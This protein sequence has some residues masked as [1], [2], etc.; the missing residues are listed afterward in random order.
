MRTTSESRLQA[1]L[2]YIRDYHKKNSATPGYRAIQKALGYSSLSIVAADVKKLKER[3]WIDSEDEYGKARIAVPSSLKMEGVRP[4]SIVG[5][6]ACGEPI[7]AIENI[8]AT[9]AL[10]I[11]IF[12]NEEHIILRAKGRSMIQRGIFPGDLMVVRVTPTAEVGD[13][14]IARVNGEE[15]TAKILCK[16]GKK[17]YLQAAN[18][19]VDENGEK[20]YK[21][22]YPVGEWDIVG[23]V[24]N[25]I[26]RPV[27]DIRI[28]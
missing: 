20:K 15:A 26:H 2:D 3:G 24:D 14:V 5:A 25:V 27:E 21:D 19:E 4:T 12:G 7:T 23:V 6:C 17:F 1:L 28:D 11:E 10:P 22:I 9:V 13:V 18:D 16:K 8:E